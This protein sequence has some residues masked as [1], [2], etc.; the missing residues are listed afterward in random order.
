MEREHDHK[1]VEPDDCALED[2]EGDAILECLGKHDVSDWRTCVP[3]DWGTLPHDGPGQCH[4]KLFV[5]I[6][7]SQADIFRMFRGLTRYLKMCPETGRILFY[8]VPPANGIPEFLERLRLVWLGFRAE[9]ERCLPAQSAGSP[10]VIRIVVRGYDRVCFFMTTGRPAGGRDLFNWWRANQ[11]IRRSRLRE[12]VRLTARLNVEHDRHCAFIGQYTNQP[13]GFNGINA[14]TYGDYTGKAHKIALWRMRIYLGSL[15]PIM[16]VGISG[17][18][19]RPNPPAMRQ[20]FE[21]RP[22]TVSWVAAD[23]ADFYRD[24]RSYCTCP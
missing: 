17:L 19:R 24:P 3:E 22:E 6:Y 2:H 9:L 21:H 1:P 13:A 15:D 18:V 12:A 5:P 20:G 4:R 16:P 11:P 23:M 10:P 14:L 7:G 8:A